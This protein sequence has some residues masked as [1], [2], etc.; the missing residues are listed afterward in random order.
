MAQAARFDAHPL[1][2]FQLL[3]EKWGAAQIGT[4][5]CWVLWDPETIRDAVSHTTGQALSDTAEATIQSLLSCIV[6]HAPWQNPRLHGICIIGLAN[7][8]PDPEEMLPTPTPGQLVFGMNV[9]NDI[10]ER[11]VLATVV[12]YQAACLLH[13]G[14]L[15]CGQPLTEADAVLARTVDTQD[16]AR[17]REFIV[18]DLEVDDDDAGAVAAARWQCAQHFAQVL[19]NH[20]LWYSD[21][22]F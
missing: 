11:P 14:I 16:R 5:D 17:A 7:G 19:D 9:L 12:E 10:E 13:H 4:Q 20:T 22:F 15:A 1:V 18:K 2:W 21:L 6:S 8:V 3:E